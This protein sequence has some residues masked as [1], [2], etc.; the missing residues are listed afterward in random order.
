MKM[1]TKYFGEIEVRDKECIE[2]SNGL[3]GFENYH[4]FVLLPVDEL[5]AYYA[6]QS[7]KEAGVCLIVTNPYHFYKDY[8]FDIDPE[9]LGIQSQEDIAIYNVVT[10]RN[11]FEKSTI[12]LQA[13]IVMNTR[14]RKAKQLI[15][16]QVD[17]RTKHPLTPAVKGGESHAR[18]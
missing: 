1:K 3:P 14:Q 11:P 6:L 16:N 9:E 13:P 7:V 2:F 10:L 15:L 4:S 18:P 12:N 17:Y 8:E 5:G